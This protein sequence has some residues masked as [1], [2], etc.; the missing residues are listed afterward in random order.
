MWQTLCIL[1][2]AFPGPKADSQ[3]G[4][5]AQEAIQTVDDGRGTPYKVEKSDNICGLVEPRQLTKPVQVDYDALLEATPEHKKLVKKKIDPNSAEGIKL[6]S[7]ARDRVRIACESVRA[8]GAYCSVW[9][10]IA[11]RD[12]TTIQDVT[13]LVRKSL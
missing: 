1:F 2:I 13:A 12:G 9:K 4:H 3:T 8:Q 5:P 6:L 11:R 7:E 10:A